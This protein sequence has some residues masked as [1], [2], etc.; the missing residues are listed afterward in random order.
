MREE[1]PP[2]FFLIANHDDI[3]RSYGL[4]LYIR[5]R[6]D[7]GRTMPDLRGLFSRAGVPPTSMASLEQEIESSLWRER[8]LATFASVFAAIAALLSAVGLYG[9]LAHS[10]RRR[11]REIG[12]RI[13]LGAGVTRV[14]GLVGRDVAACLLPG[15]LAG[16]LVY[17]G[18]SRYIAPLL[19]GVRAFELPLLAAGAIFIAI[20]A[21]LSGLIPAHRAISIH[22][23]EALRED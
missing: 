2:T 14:A 23:A 22:P 5:V 15:L 7:T 19:Y 21:V 3:D 8:I 1:A 10:I 13:A 11:T 20:V 17:F 9:M 4:I 6:G 18:C 16:V 12:I